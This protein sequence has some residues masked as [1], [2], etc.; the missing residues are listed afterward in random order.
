MQSICQRLARSCKRAATTARP[1][2]LPAYLH[3]RALSRRACENVRLCDEHCRIWKRRDVDA[4][5]RSKR[6]PE[7]DVS[8][9]TATRRTLSICSRLQPWRLVDTVITVHAD[10]R[11][12]E[13]KLVERRGRKTT[14]LKRAVAM[15]AGSHDGLGLASRAPSLGR[16][17][18]VEGSAS[19]LARFVRAAL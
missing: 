15:I 1:A 17:A 14:G 10:S 16:C 12:S 4:P 5:R 2:R 7:R 19:L 13:G 3:C 9:N 18:L 11:P 8:T 6:G